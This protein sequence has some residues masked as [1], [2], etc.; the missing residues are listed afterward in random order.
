MTLDHISHFSKKMKCLIGCYFLFFFLNSNK[1]LFRI[2]LSGKNIFFLVYIQISFKLTS[3]PQL[4]NYNVICEQFPEIMQARQ[5]EVLALIQ[6]PHNAVSLQCHFF[7]TGLYLS[8]H[9]YFQIVCI[10]L[11]HHVQICCLLM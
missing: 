10:F 9:G 4:L 8:E 3:Y 7:I 2:I 5:A 1:V 11:K 6:Y